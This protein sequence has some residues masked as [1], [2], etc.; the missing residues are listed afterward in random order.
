MAVNARDNFA[1]FCVGV[2]GDGEVWAF[3]GSRDGLRGRCARKWDGRWV[4]EGDGGGGELWSDWVRGDGGL[5]VVER[6]VVFNGRKHVVVVW[7]CWWR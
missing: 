5:D 4:D 7:K 6:G 3:D 1:F 2:G